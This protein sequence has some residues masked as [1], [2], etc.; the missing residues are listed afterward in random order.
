MNAI[1]A[2]CDT[3]R[4]CLFQC[5]D[6]EASAGDIAVCAQFHA[7][8]GF[9]LTADYATLPI[10]FL[11]CHISQIL[12]FAILHKD[13][14]A[15][16]SLMELPQMNTTL[17]F[18]IMPAIILACE[19]DEVALGMRIFLGENYADL[20]QERI[21]EAY[22]AIAI[23][24]ARMHF[25]VSMLNVAAVFG[26]RCTDFRINPLYLAI[27]ENASPCP[28][29][30]DAI[31]TWQKAQLFAKATT[32]QTII[33]N[34]AS[35]PNFLLD[36]TRQMEIDVPFSWEE[37]NY[38]IECENFSSL[39]TILLKI[40]DAYH[41]DTNCATAAQYAIDHKQ[42]AFARKIIAKYKIDGTLLKFSGDSTLNALILSLIHK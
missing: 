15:I 37:A 25:A 20:P 11:I 27:R 18:Y 5:G 23:S 30:S 10:D 32:W 8:G 41:F 19:L 24:A 12:G 17:R 33:A 42:Y 22:N 16:K 9:H 2:L 6:E 35:V 39:E 38:A 13:E 31:N 4:R 21:A 3:N 26:K 34:A 29:S 1:C 7:G 40:S 14:D 28:L 36:V